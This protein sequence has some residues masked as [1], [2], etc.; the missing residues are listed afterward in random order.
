MMSS[1]LS[2]WNNAALQRTAP[3]LPRRPISALVVTTWSSGGSAT[4]A[5]G[6]RQGSS[7]SA[8]VSSTGVG[9]RA[10][11]ETLA[12]SRTAD[13]SRALASQTKPAEGRRRE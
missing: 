5:L 11:C 2:L 12:N 6:N 9:T 4:K 3:L 1:A 8:Q 13:R 10:D 7:G